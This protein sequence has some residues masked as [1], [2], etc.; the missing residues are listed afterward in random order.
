[1][2]FPFGLYY[3]KSAMY[4]FVKYK[5]FLG[6]NHKLITSHKQRKTKER[7]NLQENMK[8]AAILLVTCVLFSLLPSHLSQGLLI[9]LLRLPFCSSKFA[10]RKQVWFNFFFFCWWWIRWRIK[11]EYWCAEKAMVSV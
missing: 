1:M 3:I 5:F 4:I 6:D 7:K 8:F 11:H 9:I 2:N 10:W